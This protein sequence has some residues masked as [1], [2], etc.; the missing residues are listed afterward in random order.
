MPV[1][2]HHLT[3]VSDTRAHICSSSWTSLSA[4]QPDSNMQDKYMRRQ[5]LFPGSI[6]EQLVITGRYSWNHKYCW[7]LH[8]TLLPTTMTIRESAWSCMSFDQMSKPKLQTL[9]KCRVTVTD[10]SLSKQQASG[11]PCAKGLADCIL[12]CCSEWTSQ[13]TSQMLTS[14]V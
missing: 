12:C 9:S 1:F 6:H 8:G 11:V 13:L 3:L 2:S 10:T 14:R 7:T 5:R 4:S